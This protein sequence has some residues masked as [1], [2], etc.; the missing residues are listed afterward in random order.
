MQIRNHFNIKPVGLIVGYIPVVSNSRVIQ[1]CAGTNSKNVR[2]RYFL[3]FGS[4]S[5]LFVFWRKPQDSEFDFAYVR[6]DF[7][8]TM[9]EARD[10][11]GV[12]RLKVKFWKFYQCKFV[13]SEVRKFWVRSTT[14]LEC[15][16]VLQ[17]APK[18]LFLSII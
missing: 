1:S 9:F 16:K 14:T 10:F 11:G 17:S 8:G 5:S 2:V 15:F 4:S 7:G 12:C 6:P 13:L 3:R 18:W